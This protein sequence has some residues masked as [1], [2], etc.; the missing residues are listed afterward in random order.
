[1]NWPG[2]SA[3]ATAKLQPWYAVHD[4]S[5]ELISAAIQPAIE[6]T[7]QAFACFDVTFFFRHG[8]VGGVSVS[9]LVLVRNVLLLMYCVRHVHTRHIQFVTGAN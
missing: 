7:L 6:T 8:D 9:I 1:M 5:H 2:M 3:R 4:P